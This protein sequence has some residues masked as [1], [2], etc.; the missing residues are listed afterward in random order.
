MSLSLQ[1]CLQDNVIFINLKLLHEGAVL[2]WSLKKG[3]PTDLQYSS[4]ST[5]TEWLHG[6][7]KCWI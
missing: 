1:E 2:N 3:L 4:C 7:K 5:Y 6:G